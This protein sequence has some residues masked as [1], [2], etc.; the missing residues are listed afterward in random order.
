M[1]SS[2]DAASRRKIGRKLALLALGANLPSLAGPPIET[3]RRA[4]CLLADQ[5]LALHAVSRFWTSPAHPAGSGP[6]Y[7]NAAA[8]IAT[9]R[10][11]QSVLDTLHGIEA[12]LGRTRSGR[13][14]DA[15]GIDLDLIGMDDHVLPDAAAQDHWRAL[16][17]AEQARIA[18]DR[19]ILPHPRM[20][21]RGFVLLPLA[22]IAPGWT[23]P[24][25]G[26]TV[27]QMLAA[28]PKGARAGIVP[29]AIQPSMG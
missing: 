9:E 5:G 17:P 13:R 16:P 12:A 7:V 22:E 21:D 8:L 14:W 19:L 1:D 15:R 24:R 18:P 26:L 2:L 4:L 11:P 29:L 3:L 6:D 27:G 20:Q 28:L 23:H 25:T 10:P